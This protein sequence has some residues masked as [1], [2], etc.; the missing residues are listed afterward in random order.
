MLIGWFSFEESTDTGINAK[1]I[2]LDSIATNTQ[3]KPIRTKSCFIRNSTKKKPYTLGKDIGLKG[4]N[5]M[6]IL[7]GDVN[8]LNRYTKVHIPIRTIPMCKALIGK[9]Y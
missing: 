2:Q 8:N 6:S 1:V 3:I 4:L 5:I 7:I 9:S